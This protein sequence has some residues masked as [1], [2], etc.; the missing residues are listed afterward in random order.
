MIEDSGTAQ[1][2]LL[3]IGDIR[4]DS[5]G[6]TLFRCDDLSAAGTVEMKNLLADVVARLTSRHITAREMISKL[7]DY[8][9]NSA[10]E[11][12]ISGEKPGEPAKPESVF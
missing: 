12:A 1:F 8:F 6:V 3:P 4:I 9:G 2:N 5:F 7:E 11:V 10:L